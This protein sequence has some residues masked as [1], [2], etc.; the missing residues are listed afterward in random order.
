MR[1]T[2][3]GSCHCG[4]VRFE[5]D[6]DLTQGTSRCNCSVCA[7][8]RFWKVI[9]GGDELRVVTGS[10]KLIAYRFGG[11]AITHFFC[12][13]CGMKPFGQGEMESMG[14]FYGVNV[15]CLDD[16]PVKDLVAAP[17]EYQDGLHD[18]WERRPQEVRHL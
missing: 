7:K 15:A 11:G 1:K 8:G 18:H 4:A 2:Y 16:M 12:D 14:K 5:A 3:H 13:T 9:V 17:L 6:I 10:E